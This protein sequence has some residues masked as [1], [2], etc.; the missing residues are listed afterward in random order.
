[1]IRSWNRGAGALR[2]PVQL[3]VALV[4]VTVLATTVPLSAANVGRARIRLT[5]FQYYQWWGASGLTLV[6]YRVTSRGGG[7]VGSVI[8]GMEDCIDESD[9]LLWSSF[10][11]VD[12]PIRGLKFTPYSTN[13]TFYFYLEGQWEKRKI[14]VAVVDDGEVDQGTVNGPG[15]VGASVSLSIIRGAEVAF[16]TISGDGRFDALDTTTL[17]VTSSGAPWDL[18]YDIDISA[19][20]DGAEVETVRRV[21][22]V[23]VEQMSGATGTTEVDVEYALEIEEKDF[24]GLPQGAYVLSITYTV[25]ADP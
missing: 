2:R 7:P 24:D 13:Q 15:C 8:I 21:F 1:M 17:R 16:P 20:P 18:T 23:D 25:T 5:Y 14:P 12:E 9:V 19:A 10:E 22:L 4:L 3:I 6:G 11:W